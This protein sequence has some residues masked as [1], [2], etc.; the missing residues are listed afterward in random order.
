[1]TQDLAYLDGY[2]QEV[3]N[4]QPLSNLQTAQEVVDTVN[5]SVDA[6]NVLV[7]AATSSNANAV[8]LNTFNVI[9]GQ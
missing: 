6:I 4:H 2:N 9:L 1:M 8:E 7:S 5:A 3:L